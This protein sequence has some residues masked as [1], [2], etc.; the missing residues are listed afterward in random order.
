[1]PHRAAARLRELIADLD[2]AQSASAELADQARKELADLA[3]NGE[4]KP[5]GAG[6]TVRRMKKGKKKR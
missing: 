4:L 1:M 2:R 6:S 3:R 5:A